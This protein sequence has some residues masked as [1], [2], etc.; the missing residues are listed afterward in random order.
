MILIILGIIIAIYSFINYKK[1][2]IWFMVYQLFVSFGIQLIKIGNLSIPLGTTLS[3]L[4]LILF[5][6]DK[7]YNKTKKDVFPFKI[8]FILIII[9]RI[10]TCFTTLGTFLEEFTRA[11]SFIFQNVINIYIAWKIFDSKEDFIY[12]YK[13][14]TIVFFIA[15][16]LGYIEFYLQYNPYTNYEKSFIGEGINYYSIER[17]RGYRLTSIFEH[18]IGAGMNFV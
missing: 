14:V 7:K 1:A 3:L 4:F 9:S 5:I 11:L 13:L 17:A 10:M 2:F 18:P 15:C 12:F 16:I 6:L 8:A